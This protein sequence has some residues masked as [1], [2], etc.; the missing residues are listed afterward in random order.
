M[1]PDPQ[2]STASTP[3]GGT[4]F[5]VVVAGGGLRIG[6]PAGA[7]GAGT[8]PGISL[9]ASSARDLAFFLARIDAEPG[10]EFHRP[11]GIVVGTDRRTV[12][13]HAIR[14]ADGVWQLELGAELDR[15]R[16]PDRS[17]LVD[18]RLAELATMVWVTDEQRL[19]R[20]F[21]EAW[22]SFV[23]WSLDDLLGWGWMR[24]IHPDDLLPLLETYEAAQRAGRGFECAARV[25][26]RVERYWWMLTRAAPRLTGD[27][28]AGFVG[29]CEV[30]D[31]DAELEEPP[32][33]A[34]LTDVLPIADL[35]GLPPAEVVGRLARLNGFLEVSR[36]AEAVEAA[37]L[38]R[39]AARW[40][41]QHPGLR[42]R[43]DEIMLVV[44][45]AAANA[46]LH[47]YPGVD[48]RVQLR[49]EMFDRHAEIR[50][51][52]WG[53]W[54]ESP[55]D[56]DSRGLQIMTALTDHLAVNTRVDGTE[57]VLRFDLR[58]SSAPAR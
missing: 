36:P 14:G 1:A 24:C 57:V 43:H 45:E 20:W 8:A 27:A 50:V 38:R 17:D 41:V 39:L 28:F 12:E 19:A 16:A 18:P 49:C 53:C 29:M 2:D 44:G 46:T 26:D 37:L 11:V 55:S 54:S 35:T 42:D 48:G 56:H 33:P 32:H 58:P 9:D 22:L 40:A 21:N 13:L 47:A 30:L 52:D 25:L 23:G 31:A 15:V 51:R 3:P 6:L 4:P 7:T 5:D 10:A 34:G